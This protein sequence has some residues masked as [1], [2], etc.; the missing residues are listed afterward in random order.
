MDDII[1]EFLIETSES[2]DELDTALI[3]LEQDPQNEVLISKIFRFIHTIKGTC[4]FLGLSRLERVAHRGED[5]LSLFRDKKLMVTPEYISTI[6]KCIDQIKEIIE[7]LQETKEEPEGDDSA[8]I[9]ELESVCADAGSPAGGSPFADNPFADNDSADEGQPNA[10]S[11]MPSM[12]QIDA[13]IAANSSEDAS[14]AEDAQT[15]SAEAVNAQVDDG[16]EALPEI[17]GIVWPEGLQPKA[18]QAP[19]A[20]MVEDVAQTPAATMAQKPAGMKIQELPVRA[21]TASGKPLDVNIQQAGQDRETIRVM[22][23][24][25]GNIITLN[26]KREKS[27]SSDHAMAGVN[28]NKTS[29]SKQES[30]DQDGNFSKQEQD[31]NV[32]SSLV[33]TRKVE[34]KHEREETE[35]KAGGAAAGSA[36]PAPSKPAAAKPKPPAPGGV[37]GAPPAH[38]GTTQTL[39]VNVEVLEGLMTTVSELVLTRNQLLQTARK[40]EDNELLA[41][42]QRLNF[43]VSELQEGV[44]KTRMQPIGNAWSKL[45]RIVRD[46]SL[47]LGKKVDLEMSGQDTELDRQVLEMIKDPLTHMVRN[48]VDHGIEMPDDRIEV[49]KPAAGKIYLRSYHQGGHIIIE[50]ADDGK[51]L[52]IAM[53]KDKLVTKGI[54]TEEQVER[55][56]AQ[57]IQQYIFH[58]GFSTAATISA[59]SGRGVGMDV[60]RTNIENIG[61]SI[62]LNSVEGSGTTFII[63]IPLTLA[64]VSALIVGVGKERFAIPQLTV[65]ELVMVG[66]DTGTEIEHV[67]NVPLLRLRNSLLPL[68]SLS[69][70]LGLTP[71][72]ALDIDP[73]KDNYVI[74]SN[75]ASFQFGILVDHVYDMEEIV[76]KPVSRNLKKLTLFSG[77][78]ILGDGQVI[79]ILDP[80]GILKTA[81]LD[82][83]LKLAVDNNKKRDEDLL[84]HRRG[85]EERLLLFSVGEKTNVKAVPLSMISRLEEVSLDRIE[86][87]G[88]RMVIQQD[89]RLLPVYSYDAELLSKPRMIEGEDGQ[90]QDLN[91]SLIIF[92]MDNKMAMVGLLVDRIINITS[93]YG[94]VNYEGEDKIFESVIINDHAAEIINPSWFSRHAPL[95]EHNG[96]KGIIEKAVEGSVEHV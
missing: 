54:A 61:G 28:L 91:R 35:I 78:T 33:F 95:I 10:D 15:V 5:V 37:D 43:V 84:E 32:E 79:M 82:E 36:K 52:P 4:G 22:R 8:L 76:I 44:M 16:A 1:D 92:N 11:G 48:S 74:V 50:I 39:R 29:S 69:K 14:P 86:M 27:E 21:S 38:E 40:F 64:I 45:P 68:V 87:T 80:T 53:I 13:M 70:L 30:H 20:A 12:D 56:S 3:E 9:A 34:K 81:G 96:F 94:K 65:R 83:G 2:L 63:K 58:A 19:E 71:P 49:G 26:Q 75:V 77:N 42:L 60:V 62:E 31:V 46:T 6:L 72:G 24:D 51:G 23:D 89:G 85:P 59:I 18:K 73:T 90:E 7:H 57:Q 93:Y 55:M 25:E 66:N 17:K 88:G 41:P 67:N 47:E